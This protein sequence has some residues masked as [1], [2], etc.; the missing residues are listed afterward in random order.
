MRK[1]K[2]IDSQQ[3][4][5][6]L[7]FKL[8]E[9]QSSSAYYK[10]IAERVGRG[11]L[12]ELKQLGEY[13]EQVK[14][15]KQLAEQERAQLLSI[16]DSIDEIIYVSE[17]E[18][19]IV[20]YANRLALEHGV[21]SEGITFR[22]ALFGPHDSS[23][24]IPGNAEVAAAGGQPLVSE[25]RHPANNK[26]Y[27]II[28]RNLS[29]P[30]GE[31]VRCDMFVD[32]TEARK[33]EDE[34]I[35]RQKMESVGRLAGGIAHDFNNILLA[36]VGSLS[37]IEIT[38]SKQERDELLEEIN[39][40]CRRATELNNQ[41]LTFSKGGA[42]VLKTASL[43]ELITK[44]VKFVLRGAQSRAEFNIPD[45][46]RP[47]E[48]DE[49]QVSQVIQ[50]I[51]INA[52]QAMAGGGTIWVSAENKSFCGKEG[53]SITIRDEGVGVAEA[54]RTRIFEPYFT[55]KANGHGLGLAA[56]YAIIKNHGG[57]I[58]ENSQQGKGAS[59][60]VWLQA[61][62]KE[63]LQAAPVRRK[64]HK[65]KGRILVMDDEP[66]VLH[67]IERFLMR[68]GY[69]FVGATNGEQAIEI[70]RDEKNS[71]NPV[72]AVIMDLTITGGMGG[73]ETLKHLKEID[74]NVNAIVSSGYSND[75]VMSNFQ[76]YGF[77]DVLR[78]PY[79]LK[80][81]GEVLERLVEQD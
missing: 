21:I 70:Y 25:F 39:D 71:D 68:L 49:V 9:A 57:T 53:V 60:E 11:R 34:V 47:A 43:K 73:V 14:A 8:K 66:L 42:P 16:F 81:I 50:N 64:I 35:L 12:R 18:S 78:K 69:D 26:L 2:P 55:T 67:T 61:S 15:S 33:L 22:D 44:T 63:P 37:L 65:G 6:A 45:D 17:I 10:R 19:E 62:H 30:S 40:A 76:Q 3:E 7:R 79:S 51:I 58:T 75:P 80:D 23:G 27:R 31:T 13:V 29:W 54:H 36:I 77:Q 72:A 4:L 28:S 48:I 41:L 74:G 59:F 52:D 24:L 5:A 20:I 32:I 1:D 56:S 46:L 38:D